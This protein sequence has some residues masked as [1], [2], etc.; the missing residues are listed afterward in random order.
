[1]VQANP[2]HC[3]FPAARTCCVC[4]CVCFSSETCPSCRQ[5][6]RFDQIRQV[7]LDF[8]DDE[9][10]ASS[11]ARIASLPSRDTEKSKDLEET[12]KVLIEHIDADSWKTEEI[13]NNM[14]D[15]DT[16]SEEI[17]MLRSMIDEHSENTKDSLTALDD[18]IARYESQEHALLEKSQELNALSDRYN[19][20]QNEIQL[21]HLQLRGKDHNLAVLDEQLA[22]TKSALDEQLMVADELHRKVNTANGENGALNKKLRMA[23]RIHSV[24]IAEL[25][26]NMSAMNKTAIRNRW[27]GSQM[28]ARLSQFNGGQMSG[29]PNNNERSVVPYTGH[30]ESWDFMMVPKL[31]K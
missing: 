30:I 9:L 17:S 25:Y 19:E 11:T 27:F 8:A 13:D 5:I 29:D 26:A 21:C 4:V 28:N 10:L 6:T 15:F 16:H 12:L 1:M 2:H 3:I 24:V 20:L 7:Y 18:A 14:V 31:K 22:K 23:H